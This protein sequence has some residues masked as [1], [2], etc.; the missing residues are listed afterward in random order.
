MTATGHRG[1]K[2]SVR[3]IAERVAACPGVAGLS[4]GRLGTVA[5]PLPGH[6]VQG[7]AVHGDEIEIHVAA[8]YGT[9]LPELA[10][11]VRDA[12]GDLAGGRQVHVV[13]D[14]VVIEDAGRGPAKG[15]QS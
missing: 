7:V 11:S 13:I 9:R 14:D 10:R 6:T 8:R 12:V 5:T 15:Q 4:G 1:G 2:A 3:E